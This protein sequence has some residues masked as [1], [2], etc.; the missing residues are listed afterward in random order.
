[1]VYD[2]TGPWKPDNVGPHSPFSSAEEA[3]RFWLG[4]RKT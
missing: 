2:K 4:E 3:I 1:M